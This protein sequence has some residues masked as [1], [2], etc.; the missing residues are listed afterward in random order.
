[1]T[2][3]ILAAVFFTFVSYAIVSSIGQPQHTYRASV[4]V[5]IAR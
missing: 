2:K 4:G 3:N 1:M 5:T